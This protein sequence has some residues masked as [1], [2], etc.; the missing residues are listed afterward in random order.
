MGGNMYL[1]ISEKSRLKDGKFCAFFSQECVQQTW[2][3]REAFFQ[4]LQTLQ[5]GTLSDAREAGVDILMGTDNPYLP[6]ATMHSELESYTLAGYTPFEALSIATLENARALGI[7]HDL[8]TIETGKLAD[9]I[10]L[11]EN[12][13]TDVRNTHKIWRVLKGGIVFDPT[14]LTP[15]PSR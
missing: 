1:W 15:S 10:V 6:G 5:W 12:P 14:E 7:E 13:L 2:T 8:G 11:D 4:G 9:L 3:T